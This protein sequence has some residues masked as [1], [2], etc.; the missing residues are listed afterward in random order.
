MSHPDGEEFVH[1]NDLSRRQLET[2]SRHAVTAKC[3][4]A[5][6]RY[7]SVRRMKRQMV[8]ARLSDPRSTPMLGGNYDIPAENQPSYRNIQ[9]NTCVLAP[10]ITEG[11][12]FVQNE[13]LRN[14]IRESQPGVDLELD[15]GVMD[16]RTCQPLS[17]ALV[18]IWS[19]NSTGFYSSFT[20][21]PALDPIV[22]PVSTDPVFTNSASMS[23]LVELGS[24]NLR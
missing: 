14:D 13:L 11:P 10:E 5:I 2:T 6:S 21:A 15:I 24:E 22:L 8:K 23:R 18:Q 12:Y 17:K 3:A 16:I 7:N 20:K 1:P 4:R 19:C 9:N